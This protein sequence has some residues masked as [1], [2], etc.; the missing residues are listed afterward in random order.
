MMAGTQLPK[1]SVCVI[2]FNQEQYIGQ[3]LQSIVDQVTDFPFEV[4]VGDD[5]SIDGTRQVIESFAHRYPDLIKPIYQEEN[6]G[7][8][9]HNLLSVHAQAKGEYVAHVD[10]DDYCLPG[11]LQ[12]QADLLDSDPECNIV[13]HR[14]LLL[15]SEGEIR[16]GAFS[17]LR[18]IGAMR[19]DRGA[20]LQFMAIG[21][22][23]SKMYRRNVAVYEI[24]KLDIIDYFLNVEQVADGVARY[25]GNEPYGVYRLI[26]GIASGG[27]RSKRALA[28]T[29]IY[30]GKKYPNY[31]MEINTA[32][33]TCLLADLRRGR[34]T[35][36]LFLKVWLRTFHFFS[37]F[38]LWR[39]RNFLRHLRFAR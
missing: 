16:E 9:V 17:E 6:I 14:M 27:T 7:A 19:F 11:K 34:S 36:A 38:N 30:F 31:R 3:C 12:V 23:S 29:L 2:A 4:I 21:L 28:A 5:C 37:A 25:S 35:W 33:L 8:G 13:F 24:P 32:A 10:G 20:M 39:N 18:T 15:S 1:V 22:H 26:D